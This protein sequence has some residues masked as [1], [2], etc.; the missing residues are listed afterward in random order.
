MRRGQQRTTPLGLTGTWAQAKDGKGGRVDAGHSGGSRHA[1][2]S[3]D[4]SNRLWHE[5]D[6]FKF[7]VDDVPHQYRMWR[8]VD[9]K[10]V[11]RRLMLLVGGGR[12]RSK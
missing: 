10:R 6:G 3:A 2:R 5:K 4:M 9:R 11:G 8:A 12:I 7:Q 1:A